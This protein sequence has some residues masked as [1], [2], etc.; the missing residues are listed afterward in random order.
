MRLKKTPDMRL[1]FLFLILIN[2]LIYLWYTFYSEPLQATTQIPFGAAPKLVLLSEAGEIKTTQEATDQGPP[3]LSADVPDAPVQRCY[4]LGP[5]MNKE[6]MV[7]ASQTLTLSGRAFEK[8]VS[9]KKE[10]I[11]YWV[12]LPPFSSIEKAQEKAQEFKLLGDRHFYVV[13]SPS[14]Y[15]NAISLGVF[16]DKE[17]AQRRHRQIRNLGYEARLEGRFRQNPVFWLDYTEIPDIQALD[18]REMVGAQRLPRS[19]ETVAS[20]PALQ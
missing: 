4:T 18:T 2:G 11:G 12:Y 5:F 8:R 17:N 14:E 3:A 6:I 19:C 13:K 10:Q 1:L 9:E 16:R 15:A 20:A 7:E